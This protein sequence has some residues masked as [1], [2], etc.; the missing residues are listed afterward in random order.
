MSLTHSVTRA[1]ASLGVKIS[2]ASAVMVAASV[3]SAPMAFASGSPTFYVDVNGSGTSCTAV[4]PCGSIAQALSDASGSNH[5]VI[6]VGPGSFYEDDI[7]TPAGKYTISGIPG[8]T[9]LIADT[10]SNNGFDVATSDLVVS[11]VT[12]NGYG[13]GVYNLGGTVTLENDVFT[14]NYDGVYTSGTTMVSDSTFDTNVTAGVNVVGGFTSVDSSTFTNNEVGVY[15]QSG[16][17]SVVNTTTQGNDVGL[18]SNATLTVSQ[19]TITDNASYGIF[20]SGTVNLTSSILERNGA[21][22]SGAISNDNGYNVDDDVTNACA[23]AGY[24]GD[25]VGSLAHTESLSDNGGPTLTEAILPTSPAYDFVP[26]AYCA[27]LDQRGATRLLASNPNFCDAGAYQW[28]PPATIALTTDPLTGI[29]SFTPNIGPVTVEMYDAAG[30]PAVS[31]KVVTLALSTTAP[32]GF[33][34]IANGASPTSSVTIPIGESSVGIWLGSLHPVAFHATISNAKLGTLT[35]TETITHGPPA[36]ETITGGNSQS[37]IVGDDFASALSVNVVDAQGNVVPGAQIDW[38]ITTGAASFPGSS[39]VA[40]T[41]TDSSGNSSAPTLTAGHTPSTIFVTATVDGTAIIQTFTET[42]LTGPPHDISITAGTP[43]EQTPTATFSIDLTAHVVDK[44]GNPVNG[45]QVDF[46]VA[47]GSASLTSPNATTNPSGDASDTMVAGTTAGPVTVTATVDGTAITATADHLTV[48]PGAPDAITV[49]SGDAQSTTPTSDFTNPL[50]VSVVDHWGNA[51]APTQ[52]DFEVTSGSA[53]PSATSAVT[54]SSGDATVNLTA[55]TVAGPVTVTATV[56][57]TVITTTFNETVIPGPPAAITIIGGNNQSELP[58]SSFHDELQVSVTDA[59]GNAVAP[60][61]VDFAVTAGSAELDTATATTD[62]SGDASDALDTGSV[63]GPV[64]VTATVDGTAITTTFDETVIPG[65]PASIVIVQGNNQSATPAIDVP[66]DLGVSVTDAW[67]NAVAPTQVDFAVTS[68]SAFTDNDSVIT[69]SSGVA[70][71]GLDSGTV[72][73]PVTVTA[74]VDGSSLTTTFDETVIPGAPSVLTVTGGANQSAFSDTNFSV[75]LSTSL[76]DSWGNLI[77]NA[78][79]TYHVTSGSARFSG[80]TQMTVTTLGGLSEVALRAGDHAGPQTVTATVDGSA[81]LTSFLGIVV[82]AP[83]YSKTISG[84]AVGSSVLTAAQKVT[85]TLTAHSIARLGNTKVA[86]T[87]YA[88]ETG[89]TSQNNS[90]SLAR[91]NSARTFLRSVLNKLA[92]SGV[93]ITTQ[94]LGSTHLLKGVPA[95][96]PLNR[97]AVLWM[98]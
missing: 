96:S 86:I 17:A 29:T 56:D 71:D 59:W 34:G 37:A 66:T 23:L 70:T 88:D 83:V 3:A 75:L 43:Q 7:I 47:S 68:G 4:A 11:G 5:G 81:V 38:S 78:H 52:V 1:R 12:F 16:T 57:G 44:Y 84:F 20:S 46:V 19:T 73:G 13:D 76:V 8:Q 91:A 74:T 45:A 6:N 26:A 48:I 80:S 51:V 15:V 39:S 72:A 2:L 89:T 60:T 97:R 27:P 61:Q 69:D 41:T 98:S 87:G 22:C 33:F 82:K 79:V 65:S 85:L 36:T 55:D 92:V 14:Q 24:L 53:H 31:Q 9:S 58:D 64:T 67:G 93:T 28:A 42:G 35:Q 25:V 30:F 10:T 95:S 63:A 49:V 40:T 62:S 54:D 21:D 50:V 18:A 32:S 77:S 94:G 90:L